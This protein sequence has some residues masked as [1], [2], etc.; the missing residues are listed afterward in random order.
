MYLLPYVPGSDQ[1]TEL[2]AAPGW[3]HADTDI[4]LHYAETGAWAWLI[5][6]DDGLL[7]GE[8]GVKGLPADDG[9]V[10]IGYGLAAQSRGR[11]LGGRAVASLLT[12][13]RACPGVRSVEARV[14]SDNLPSRRLLERLGF[15][16]V[17]LSGEEVLYRRLV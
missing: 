14:V 15:A 4:G 11:G 10:E 1:L 2:P 16:L 12:E 3:P 6:D 5:V 13:L 17:D 7:A 9:V 8:C